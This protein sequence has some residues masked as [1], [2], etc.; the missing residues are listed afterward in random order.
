MSSSTSKAPR[1]FWSVALACLLSGTMHAADPAQPASEHVFKSFDG[2]NIHYVVAGNGPLVV[3]VHGFTG[4]GLSWTRSPLWPSLLAAGFQ[5]AALDLR[6]NGTSDKPHD[7][8]AYA[9]DAE[10]KDIA[11]LVD[12]LGATR[13]SVVGYSRGAIIAARV[14]VLDRR[15]ERGVL[16]GMGLDFTNPEW[17]RRKAFYDALSGKDVPELAAMVQ[18][19]RDRGLDQSA[20]ALSQKQQPSTSLAELKALT[21]PV[22]VIAGDRDA[23]NGSADDLARAIPGAVKATVPGDHG[24]ASRTQSFADRVVQFLRGR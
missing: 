2:T 7:E 22:L 21:V 23:D 19:V 12:T 14:L 17:P 13:F 9:N 18:S 5:V 20:L 6:G 8:A 16:G 11:H 4:D 1:S 3:L 15:I 24:S 10:A